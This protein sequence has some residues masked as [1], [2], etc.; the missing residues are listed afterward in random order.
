VSTNQLVVV[1]PRRPGGGL[2]RV[3][4]ELSKFCCVGLSGYV[5]NLLVFAAL[6]RGAGFHFALAATASFAV[7]VVNNYTWNRLWT[8]RD[9]R[10]PLIGQG[11]RF[12]VV[13]L[14]AL[15]ANVA[16]LGVLVSLS[17][18]SVVAQ[19]LAILVVTPLNFLGNR[20][21]SFAHREPS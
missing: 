14:L 8:F 6:V 4:P 7:A 9:R 17:A 10:G 18:E 19:A 20:I 11:V 12:L 13:S 2:G 3:R 5:V 1:R 15:A 21:W 16:V